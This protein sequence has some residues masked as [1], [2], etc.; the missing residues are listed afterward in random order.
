MGAMGKVWGNNFP[1]RFLVD[2]DSP[3]ARLDYGGD[4]EGLGI[5]MWQADPRPNRPILQ[6]GRALFALLPNLKRDPAQGSIP[7]KSDL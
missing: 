1:Q 7:D 3:I 5:D 4:E 6:W 2:P